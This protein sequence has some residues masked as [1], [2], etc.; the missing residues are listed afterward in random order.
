MLR[1]ADAQYSRHR[2]ETPRSPGQAGGGASVGQWRGPTEAEG[3]DLTKQNKTKSK[4]GKMIPIPE[5]TGLAVGEPCPATCSPTPRQVRRAPTLPCTRAT[6][7]N[8]LEKGPLCLPLS[9]GTPSQ[10]PRPCSRVWCHPSERDSLNPSS[11]LCPNLQAGLACGTPVPWRP[12][13]NG[14]GSIQSIPSKC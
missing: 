4:K 12:R 8:D 6:T 14:L 11:C 2:R 9:P 7:R 3:L 5:D 13:M 1:I 10:P